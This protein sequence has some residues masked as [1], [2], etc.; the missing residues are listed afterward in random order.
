MTINKYQEIEISE[1][2]F[3]PLLKW[4]LLKFEFDPSSRRSFGGRDDKI[5]GFID[6][7]A[8]QCVNWI[9]FNHLLADKDFEVDPDFFFYNEKSAKKCADVIG[10]K[11]NSGKIVPLSYFVKDEWIHEKNIPFI[12]VKTVR[13][14]QFMTSLGMPQFNDNHY[15]V[16]VESVFDDLYLFNFFNKLDINDQNLTMDSIYLK[17]NSKNIIQMPNSN[18]SEK[19]ATLRLL[20]TYKGSDLIKHNLSFSINEPIRYIKDLRSIEEVDIPPKSKGMKTMIEDDVFIYDPANQKK[21][22][23]LPIYTKANCVQI[24]HSSKMLMTKLYIEVL[25][26]CYL[27]QFKL[28]AGFYEIKFDV[29]KKTSKEVELFNHKSIYDQSNHVYESYPTDCTD[30]LINKLEAVYNQ[31]NV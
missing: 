22:Q 31:E 27:N 28:D 12:E 1:A 19:I 13:N 8:N 24:I 23:F 3:L 18:L 11:G 2:D 4:C 5:G 29:F 10:L 30:E 6:R 15:F 21:N 25:D 7:F 20:G 16:Y 9:I 17:D 26:S 14:S